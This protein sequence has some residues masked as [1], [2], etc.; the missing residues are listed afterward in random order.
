[1]R[2]SGF[3]LIELLVVIAIIAILMALLIPAVQ[4]V[5][6]EAA[7]RVACSNNLHQLGIAMH[8]YHGEVKKLPPGDFN[9][10][11]YGPSAVVALLPYVDQKAIRDLYIMTGVS[12]ASPGTASNDVAGAIRLPLLLCPSDIHR[13]DSYQF[14]WNSYHMNYG[15]WV[16]AN[17]WDGL[18]APNFTAAGAKGNAGVRFKEVADG[19]SNTAAFAE[20][21]MG[22]GNDASATGHRDPRVDC[23]EAASVGSTVS[24]AQSA[25]LGM[26]WRTAGY[27]GGSSWSPPWSWRG[28]P[29]RE[30]SIWRNGYT[31]L[32][33]PNSPCWRANGDW[34]QLI[35]PP[36]SFHGGGANVLMADGSV[37]FVADDVGPDAWT[38]AGSKAG[39]ETATLN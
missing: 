16:K 33:P 27:A 32:L 37:R 1:M 38:A 30:G 9:D 6:A 20:V 23:Y 22:L 28:Y 2:R 4:K 11:N 36:S 19:L 39:G 25:L 34:F 21:A 31:H 18:F 12:G 10:V 14:G 7:S 5:H 13:N 17:G 35:A 8:N 26:D 15:T 24:G 3:T 29:W